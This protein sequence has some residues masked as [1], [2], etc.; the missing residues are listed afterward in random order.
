V[1]PGAAE[2]EQSCGV[3]V[4]RRTVDDFGPFGSAATHRHDDGRQSMLAQ[5]A[6]QIRRHRGLPD[7]L[8]G[9]EHGDRRAMRH[10]LVARRPEF[11]IGAAV[12]GTRGQRRSRIREALRVAGDRLVGEIDDDLRPV[13]AQAALDAPQQHR[14]VDDGDAELGERVGGFQLLGPAQE[15]RRDELQA[16]VASQHVEGVADHGRIVLAVDESQSPHA[17]RLRGSTGRA[18]PGA[19]S[20]AQSVA[21]RCMSVVRQRSKR[22]SMRRTSGSSL[23]PQRARTGAVCRVSWIP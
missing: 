19:R 4:L 5:P 3:Q 1:P 6:R 18:L 9:A 10:A 7:A 22:T 12:G 11:E 17:R 2:F 16:V 21:K 20:A 15:H 8:A 23:P 14:L 13:L